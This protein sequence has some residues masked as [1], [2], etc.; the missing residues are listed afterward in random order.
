MGQTCGTNGKKCTWALRALLAALCLLYTG[1]GGIDADLKAM[2]G[3]PAVVA[4][5]YFRE[6][7]VGRP[8]IE[9][10][11]QESVYRWQWEDSS[12]SGGYWSTDYETVTTYDNKGNR[13]GYMRV[14]VNRH[15]VPKVTTYYR[16]N[17]DIYVEKG[18]VITHHT[19]RCWEERTQHE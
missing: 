17:A 13:T 1:C 6:M 7:G 9:G 4:V 12:S 2:Y 5:D 15:Y 16:C 14:P 11:A 10:N 3:Q 8:S 19:H 18:D